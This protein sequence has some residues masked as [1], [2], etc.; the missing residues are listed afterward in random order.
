MSKVINSHTAVKIKSNLITVPHV[1]SSNCSH[2]VQAEAI[3]TYSPNWIF[4][5]IVAFRRNKRA[6]SDTKRCAISSK[7]NKKIVG[8]KCMK[9]HF[10][11]NLEMRQF[12]E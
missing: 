7:Q 6:L 1:L 9:S 10:I 3:S 4:F 5:V 11:V 2:R 12:P 8:V